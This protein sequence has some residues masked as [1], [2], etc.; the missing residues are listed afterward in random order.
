MRFLLIGAAITGLLIECKPD[1]SRYEVEGTYV[2]TGM[3]KSSKLV[4]NLD[5]SFEEVE[6]RY[7]DIGPTEEKIIKG[8]FQASHNQILLFPD[9]FHVRYLHSEGNM[10]NQ[11]IDHDSAYALNQIKPNVWKY[12]NTLTIVRWNDRMFIL[13]TNKFRSEHFTS[14][15][16]YGLIND[17]NR[18]LMKNWKWRQYAATTYWNKRCNGCSQS[19][20]KK[21]LPK[22]WSQR[23]LDN[24]IEAKV[25]SV[26]QLPSG[27][28]TIHD[29]II[30]I[31]AGRADGVWP[32]MVF[33]EDPDKDSTI[34]LYVLAFEV[35]ERT[36]NAYVGVF[37]D[38]EI[39]LNLA[40]TT[41][42]PV[43]DI[44]VPHEW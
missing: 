16:M 30:T 40:L 44:S 41:S 6:S 18:G 42:A 12:S 5:G 43:E 9:F 23:L 17:I 39:P 34:L 26:M 13:G 24:P 4:L 28:R 21:A 11:K 36:S 19:D 15:D 8:K 14:P 35:D 20:I 1:L 2:S 27:I 3:W 25:E 22:E 29:R 10:R 32:G 33:Y 37:R 7:S 38:R 31:N